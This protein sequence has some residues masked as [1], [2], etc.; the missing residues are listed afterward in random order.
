PLDAQCWADMEGFNMERM[1][2][3]NPGI[4]RNVLINGKMAV[5]DGEPVAQLGQ[6]RG[7]GKF[8]R[9]GECTYV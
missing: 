5:E 9:A 3:R 1:V 4:V 7:Y 6:A 2:N 8:L